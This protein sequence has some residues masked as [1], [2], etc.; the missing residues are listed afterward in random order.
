MGMMHVTYDLRCRSHYHIADNSYYLPVSREACSLDHT[1][2]YVCIYGS[3]MALNVY[4]HSDFI[5]LD[6]RWLA[7]YLASLDWR[8]GCLYVSATESGLH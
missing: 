7:W 5:I 1:P 6:H 3:R 2:Q 8:S 4:H